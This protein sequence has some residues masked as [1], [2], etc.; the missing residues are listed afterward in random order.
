MRLAIP[1]KSTFAALVTAKDNTNNSNDC[2]VTDGR[3]D[4][5]AY[6]YY[7]N[8]LKC[9][10]NSD[11]GGIES[12]IYHSLQRLETTGIPDCRC[13]KF[14]QG[15]PWEGWLMY[16]PAGKVDLASYCGPVLDGR[17]DWDCSKDSREL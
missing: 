3:M 14:D 4:L 9:A 10:T 8:G 11:L 2:A 6:R 13:M 1:L 7:S 16:G 15:G 12:S 5:V 17:L